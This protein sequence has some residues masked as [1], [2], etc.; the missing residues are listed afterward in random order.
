M[1]RGFFLLTTLFL[2]GCADLPESNPGPRHVDP[3][4]P[5]PLSRPAVRKIIERDPSVFEATMVLD[6]LEQAP[7]LKEAREKIARETGN[8]IQGSYMPNPVLTLETEMMPI[9]DMGFG[10]ARNK[11]RIAQRIET[12]GKAGAR[13]DLAEARR[14][15]AEAAYFQVRSDLAAEA[16]TLFYDAAHAR[17][18]SESNERAE[19]LR[20]RL[21]A[22]AEE[23]NRKGRLPQQDLIT[24]QVAVAKA[25]DRLLKHRGD[26]KKFIAELEGLLG[27]PAGTILQCRHGAP[28]WEPP[29]WDE[30]AAS[31]LT[32]S[33]EL[34]R[35][36]G[37]IE[38]ARANLRLAESGKWTDITVGVGYSRGAEGMA[39]RDDF[40][41][42]FIQIPLP[43]VDRKQGAIMSAEADIRGAEASLERAAAR[44]LDEWFGNRER[45]LALAASRDLYTNSIIPSL[46]KQHGLVEGLVETGRTP[47]TRSLEIALELEAAREALIE[48]DRLM[49][50]IRAEMIKLAG[51]IQI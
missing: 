1:V 21:L 19:K 41:G 49:A 51:G 36:D 27:L 13:V 46:A 10:N 28:A 34:N 23:M 26:E 42:A 18:K 48:V 39:E 17:D 7:A 31:I 25:T 20:M 24:F 16:M 2:A 22:I 9:D 32:R 14:N 15:A 6:L 33:P 43:L 40:M 50:T 47:I 29:S 38:A 30:G 3:G 44:A 35:L 4:A 37:E 11:V 8:L 12:A 5:S 45:W